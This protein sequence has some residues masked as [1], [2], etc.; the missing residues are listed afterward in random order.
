M[1]SLKSFF[2]A[3][4]VF[5]PL[6][7]IVINTFVDSKRKSF[8]RNGAFVYILVSSVLA[9]FNH[10]QLSVDSDVV[11]NLGK[12]S[13]YTNIDD[14]SSVLVVLTQILGFFV[15]FL[16]PNFINFEDK[17]KIFYNSFLGLILGLNLTFISRDIISFYI[18]WE[19]ALLGAIILIMIF[20]LGDKVKTALTFFIYTFTG[21]LFLLL[22]LGAFAANAYNESGMMITH[23]HQLSRF[24][25]PFESS[26]LSLQGLS[27][28]AM[29]FAFM[30]KA[31]VMPLHMWMR[32]T[33]KN[34]PSIVL[35]L[36]AG[37]MGKMGTYAMIRFLP[38]FPEA[39]VSAS[40]FM[41]YLAAFGIVYGAIL[42]IRS[43]S[44]KELI[45][46]SSLSHV[47]Y[48]AMGI[49][50]LDSSAL[51]GSIMQIFNHG[52]IIAGLFIILAHL[53]KYNLENASGIQN[54]APKLSVL[55][56]IYVLASIGL[57]ITSG[58]TGEFLIFL[59][60]F[61]SIK[62]AALIG[63]LGV[64]LGA[65]YM[66][67]AYGRIFQGTWNNTNAEAPEL[68]RKSFISAILIALIIF[69]L[70]IFPMSFFKKPQQPT[71]ALTEELK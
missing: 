39:Q 50:S 20:G 11:W 21:S 31:P 48:I 25:L 34:T 6:L 61:A 42:A 62:T 57:P 19:L 5:A 30:I 9:V 29:T 41:T 22:G 1:F 37:V 12:I 24:S 13:F 58:F 54:V 51:S 44:L 56:F 63:M 70:G 14:L 23:F 27:F 68:D 8:F 52:I 49:Y 10:Y 45:T 26:W 3:L 35:V 28:I 43:K 15:I 60:T 40:H 55:F 2:I 59:G 16:A 64:I 7:L 33:Y 38:F 71:Y 32:D 46:Y 47:S 4:L 66:L 67:K 17:E 18:G 65:I 53:E 36:I 69:I